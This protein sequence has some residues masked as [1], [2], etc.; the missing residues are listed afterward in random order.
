MIR[1][2]AVTKDLKLRKGL[3]I[4]DLKDSNIQWY[5]VDFEA[6]DEKEIKYLSDYF[7][8]HHLSIE[9][10]LQF[11]ERPKLDYCGTYNFL[12]L[13]ALNQDTLA[14]EEVDVF[15]GKNYV[16]SF[17]KQP[18]DEIQSAWNQVEE[19]KELWAKGHNYIIYL[20]L[21]KII[22]EYFPAIYR[23]ED[24]LSEIDDNARRNSVKE[25]INEVFEVRGELLKLRRIV[26][27]MRDLLYR[28][29]NSDHAEG[30]KEGKLYFTD[31]Y[32]HLI[33][34][35]EMIESNR[36]VTSD[37]R[38]SYLSVMSNR[39]NT[40]MMILTVITTI[41]IPLTFIAGIYG[42]NFEYMPELKWRYGYFV[43]MGFMA[44]IALVMT[45]WFKVKGWFNIYK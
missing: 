40:I 22:D 44:L 2:I 17:H 18:S 1:I 20:I 25:L 10:C 6:P 3:K 5:W 14:A 12:V 30:F 36:D 33:K 34:L 4:A 11:L 8:F 45:L 9:D 23:I 24:Y 15:I 42:M 41:F 16:V 26:N 29:I 13:H 32:D 19:D 37:L 43:V 21:D 39:M 38:D 35:S 27:S 28:I 31:I 7:H